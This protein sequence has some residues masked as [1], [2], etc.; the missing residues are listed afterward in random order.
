MH[1]VVLSNGHE[2]RILL[3]RKIQQTQDTMV[4]I[5]SRFFHNGHD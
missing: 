4:K 1:N 2:P 5:A 3:I